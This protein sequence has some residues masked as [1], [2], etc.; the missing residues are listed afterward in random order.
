MGIG[1][2]LL[3]GYRKERSIARAPRKPKKRKVA[4]KL[5]SEEKE[6]IKSIRG[7]H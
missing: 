4:L 5:T 7:R 1:S 6:L 2:S 3:S